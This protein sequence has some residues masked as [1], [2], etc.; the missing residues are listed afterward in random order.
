MT[1][2]DVMLDRVGQAMDARLSLDDWRNLLRDITFWSTD[3]TYADVNAVVGLVAV[4]SA[5][6]A[7]DDAMATVVENLRTAVMLLQSYA[8]ALLQ[9]E[10]V[11]HLDHVDGTVSA[12]V[13]TVLETFGPKRPLE[14][15]EL[16]HAD[17]FQ[18]SRALRKLVAAGKVELDPASQ[19]EQDGRARIYR[20]TATARMPVMTSRMSS[21]S[22]G[23]DPTQ[24][25]RRGRKFGAINRLGNQV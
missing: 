23:S 8:S 10:E 14:L 24:R 21:R 9:S 4:A 17:R 25:V 11:K 3:A 19:D 1:G 16:T 15:V 7:Q 13:L 20:L 2:V 22:G 18:V 6:L 5:E 12:R